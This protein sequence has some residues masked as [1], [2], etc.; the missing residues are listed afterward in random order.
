MIMTTINTNK[1]IVDTL[2]KNG[3]I[4]KEIRKPSIKFIKSQNYGVR[5]LWARI[6]GQ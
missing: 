6:N 3:P 1:S 5:K 4:M 2:N